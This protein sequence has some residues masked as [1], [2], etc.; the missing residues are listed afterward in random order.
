MVAEHIPIPAT[1]A[2]TV[3]ARRRSPSHQ[4]DRVFGGG[5]VIF[6]AM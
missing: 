2:T 3:F 6:R 5:C 4:A 1:A